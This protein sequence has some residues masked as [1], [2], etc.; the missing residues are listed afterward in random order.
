MSTDRRSQRAS[1]HPING[2]P[3][4]R[5]SYLTMLGHWA[6]GGVASV[7]FGTVASDDA[8]DRNSKR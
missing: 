8:P 7:D 4:E 2:S 5:A 6:R 1:D 3:T